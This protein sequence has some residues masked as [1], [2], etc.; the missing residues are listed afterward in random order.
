MEPQGRFSSSSFRTAKVVFPFLLGVLSALVTP[1]A[2][3]AQLME[4]ALLAEGADRIAAEARRSGD[5]ARGAVVFHQPFLACA[6]CHSSADQQTGLG[7]LLTRL[8]ADATD[9]HLV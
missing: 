6:K 9:A 4:H 1:K 3:D 8:P 2:A 7:P 5:A